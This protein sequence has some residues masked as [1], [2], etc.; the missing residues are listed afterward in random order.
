MK[1][2]NHKLLKIST[3]LLL[4]AALFGLSL[5]HSSPV[6]AA[7]LPTDTCTLVGTVRTCDLYATTGS[8]VVDG[9]GG[10]PIW[11]YSLT[12]GVGTASLPGPMIIANAGETLVV[13]L[14]N[15][16]VETTG[17]FFTGLAMPPDLSGVAAGGMKTYTINN[18]Q[19]GTFL[20][21]AALLPNTQH[22][23]ALGMYGA[24]VVRPAGAPL[25]AYGPASAFN[26]EA[27]VILSEIDPSL[28]SLTVSPGD[29][30][31]F[32]MRDYSP[33]LFLINGAAYPATAEIASLPGNTVLLRIINV[34]LR[35]HTLNLLG[36]GQTRIATDSIAL[37]YPRRVTTANVAPGQ[38]IDT[39]V[40]MPAAAPV[41]G[42]KY[43][44]YD[45]N[46]LLHNSSAAG[47]GGMMTFITL[48]DGTT[49]TG[50]PVT[51][52]VSIAP[53]PTNGLVDV[54]LTAVIPGAIS[55]EYFVDTT[56][57]GGGGIAMAA[58]AN[59]NEWVA[60]FTSAALLDVNFASGD[61][62]FYARGS[63]GTSWG[64]FN[65]TAL[66]LDKAGPMTRAV[67]LSPNPSAGGVAVAIQATADDSMSGNSNVIAAQY[68]ID[69]MMGVPT[70]LAVSAVTPVASL[71]GNIPVSVM[72][73]LAEGEH[74]VHINAQDAFGNWGMHAMAPLKVDK[75]GP[76]A[77][78]VIATPSLLYTRTSVRL[79]VTLTDPSV[80]VDPYPGVNSTIKKAEG[81]IDVVGVDGTGFPLLPRDG[82]FNQQTEAAYATISQATINSLSEGTH[83]L[84]VH[85]QDTNGHWGV[86]GSTTFTILGQAIFSDGFESGD[87]AAWA[88]TFGN[89]S[90][91][92]GAARS[93]SFGM[94][95]GLAGTAKSYIT[96]PSPM[97]EPSYRA[98][99]HFNPNSAL[100][101]NNNAANGV[102]IFS[103]LNGSDTAIFQVQF[104]RQNA[105]GGIYQ[106][107]LSVA[108]AG[109][110]T[111]TSW[112]TI[113]NTWHSIE[114]AWNS[115]TSVSAS[116]Y[117]DG[118]L[119]QT[120]TGLNTSVNKLATVRLGPSVGTLGTSASGTMYFDDFVSRRTLYIGP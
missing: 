83:T 49:P 19:A 32:D 99:F 53:N 25:E 86:V 71:T 77:S 7:T 12:G 8:I 87:L 17:L 23:V 73:G 57:I 82:L 80:G 6:Q 93:G 37:T 69:D 61:H 107:R 89:V 84:Y 14:H 65:S 11:G 76:E 109:G 34:G 41:G 46:F 30:A 90:V 40:T 21:E 54:T 113:S 4:A 50:G 118:T 111:N 98:R 15:E 115:G 31:S 44:L 63:D 26:D 13:N 95:V 45:G 29:P 91:A 60:T 58:G 64:A 28:N 79:D 116:L 22:Q 105:G 81:F 108:R 94:Q 78:G 35:P 100:P 55:A 101:V 33:L 2:I 68:M 92:T 9:W 112:F 38:S 39:L 52:S 120:L 62:T 102:T 3:L 67:T 47:F 70:A 117:T 85:G 103:G 56:G 43:A 27:L 74:T 20:Y 114:I 10:V 48:S 51:T 75:T 42:A 5:L 97:L 96:D 66:H 36:V 59:P 18:L 1:T 119:K 106:V 72:S 16:L 104:R 88:S 24:L 110:V